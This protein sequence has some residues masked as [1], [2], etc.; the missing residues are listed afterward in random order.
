[1]KNKKH[2]TD[3][4]ILNTLSVIADTENKDAQKSLRT[5]LE[6]LTGY[7]C[8]KMC[9]CLIYKNNCFSILG[10]YSAEVNFKKFVFE[11]VIFDANDVVWEVVND[12][13]NR[14]INQHISRKI[15]IDS[16]LYSNILTGRQII[17]M[18]Q[19]NPPAGTFL[20]VCSGNDNDYTAYDNKVIRLF[21]NTLYPKLTLITQNETKTTKTESNLQPTTNQQSIKDKYETK[22]SNKLNQFEQAKK[23]LIYEIEHRKRAEKLNLQQYHLFKKLVE[24]MPIGIFA[25]NVEDGF[26][27]FVWNKVMEN[28]YN[29]AADEVINRKD[30]DIFPDDYKEIDRQDNELIK[31]KKAIVTQFKEYYSKHG[32][33]YLNIGR[34]AIE[35]QKGQLTCIIGYVQNVTH[36]H[37]T[38]LELQQYQNQLEELVEDKTQELKKA[39]IE[40][41][42]KSIKIQQQNYEYNVLNEELKSQNE[43]LYV[44]NEELEKSN[45]T[46][47][48]MNE[49]LIQ[50]R[51]NLLK[52]Q[53]AAQ[54]CNWKLNLNT[55]K[56]EISDFGY[57]LLGYQ[58]HE[59]YLYPKRLIQ[60]IYPA[61]YFPLLRTLIKTNTENNSQQLIF[62]FYT[63]KNEMRIA[64]LLSETIEHKKNKRIVFGTFQDITDIYSIETALKESE[65]RYK[66]IFDNSPI[67]LIHYNKQGVITECN[68]AFV[69]I[70]GSKQEALIGF[71]MMKSIVNKKL[72]QRI[73]MALRG[74]QSQ[75]SGLYKSVTGDKETP[76]RAD[77]IPLL[78]D[79]NE[80]KGGIGLIEDISEHT[81][82]K[83]RAKRSKNYHHLRA[84]MWELIANR[85]I[86]T[87]DALMEKLFDMV[88]KRI[89][90]S[91]IVL[92]KTV[93]KSKLIA[94]FEWYSK[95][96]EKSVGELHVTPRII[97]FI[98]KNRF[99]ELSV[100][101]IESLFDDESKQNKHVSE[102][103]Q[104]LYDIDTKFAIFFPY[105]VNNKIEGYISFQRDNS[106]ESPWQQGDIYIG[107][108]MCNIIAVII[109]KMRT[110]IDLRE[111]EE[112]Y[113]TL[114]ENSNDGIFIE[115]QRLISFTNKQFR[116]LVKYTEEEL[117]DA[118]LTKVIDVDNIKKVLDFHR[119]KYYGSTSANLLETE[120]TSKYNETIPVEFNT[121]IIKYNNLQS[122]MTIVRD[123]TSRKIA[124]MERNRL[125]AA[126]EQI[127][128]AVIITNTDSIIEYVNPAF[129]K[130]TGYS[131][132]EVKGYSTKIL[133]SGKHT[134]EFYRNLW[135]TI[136]QGETWSGNIINRKKNGKLYDEY[137]VISAI[138]NSNGDIVNYVAIKRDITDELKMEN[139]LKQT[140]KLQAIGTLAGGIAHD[141]NNILMGMLMFTE[142]IK[143]KPQNT[144][145]T[146]KNI[147]KIETAIN[148]AK[149][150][151]TQ[152]LT[153]SRQ[154]NEKNTPIL[155]DKTVKEAMKLIK[156]TMPATIKIHQHIEYCGY[157][158]GSPTNIHQVVMNLCT[159]ANHAMNGIGDM[160]V[161]L[162]I[163]CK[164]KLEKII[165]DKTVN[166]WIELKVKDTGK[167]MNEE[168]IKRIFE[169]FFTTKEVGKGTGLGMATV[170]GIIKR[171]NGFIDIKSEPGK[172]SIFY[173]YLPQ[174]S[175]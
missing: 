164:D 84:D 92:Y 116:D 172:G 73:R 1:M 137:M 10:G 83:D 140:Q 68:Q 67:G 77:F 89:N 6:F 31:S 22:L 44:L 64:R 129:E 20:V 162:T 151:V 144:E 50:H 66:N 78:S 46:I 142:L 65:A 7:T 141:F 161:S 9:V 12:D 148:R 98:S 24:F 72:L 103:K 160:Y 112:K 23:V 100:Q 40:L 29:I 154:S 113:R 52:A 135:Q 36:W 56:I 62:R 136:K 108:D 28:I 117:I 51:N 124:E 61:D 18:L 38:E 138:R 71:N 41:V 85:E 69:N 121:S 119:K 158:I 91:K 34:Y 171:H 42:E 95:P 13:K 96:S 37:K 147:E 99:T 8:S 174:H 134:P 19:Q 54:L 130:M 48:V 3:T 30:K 86:T 2:Y 163:K 125:V 4:D 53:E 60:M 101:H 26:R 152:I 70:M 145:A 156:A 170:H 27:Y 5:A 88:G 166:N 75:F 25:K 55:K 159:N 97:D 59:K 76:V 32:V 118:P 105:I 58:P 79:D 143:I 132:D 165:A 157:I 57:K 11:E 47:R 131:L 109:L 126:I 106:N 21:I 49:Q 146:L 111:N 155:I 169:P 87:E 175:E 80:V 82:A 43:E 45:E 16:T 81:R 153:F 90:A 107:I 17:C 35:N 120:L 14:I 102:I 122:S 168:V 74:E 139:N 93:N 63:R 15:T 149:D 167:G 104:L 123:L 114:V 150:L 39:N 133:N 110:E 127:Y 173:I 33:K 115:T 94:N 128:E